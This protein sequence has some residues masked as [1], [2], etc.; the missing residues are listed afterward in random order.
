MSEPCDDS[1]KG[2]TPPQLPGE[3]PFAPRSP[4]AEHYRPPRLGI[5]HLLAWTAATAVLL[6]FSMAMEMIG[7]TEGP[8]GIRFECEDG[9]I[10]VHIHGGHLEASSPSILKTEL[11]V[12]D[13]RLGRSPGHHQ[14]FL[15]AVR[16]RGVP[17]APVEAGHRTATL[18]HLAN[19]VMLVGGPLHWDPVAERFRDSAEA[20]RLLDRPARAP[21][22]I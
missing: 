1:P 15:H 3:S 19:I 8:R 14:D 2:P 20:N 21:W 4:F 9:W 5:I 18:C 22:F 6:K 7:S 17:M 13:V 11:G 10:F 12:G 16:T